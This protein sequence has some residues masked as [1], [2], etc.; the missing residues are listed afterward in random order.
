MLVALQVYLA[1]TVLQISIERFRLFYIIMIHFKT[2]LLFS[3]LLCTAG[4][5]AQTSDDCVV[6]ET[7]GGERMEFVLNEFPRITQARNRVTMQTIS[8]KVEFEVSQISKMTI[9]EKETSAIDEITAHDNNIRLSDGYIILSGYKPGERI[10]LYR[11]DGTL[12]WQQSV[13]EGGRMLVPLGQQS[14]GVY[15]VKANGQS[16][17]IIKK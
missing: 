4:L 9:Q 13:A 1:V 16:V 6:V 15:I 5:R 8:S 10:T 17:K 7:A 2:Y 14:T 12:L 3:V 11:S